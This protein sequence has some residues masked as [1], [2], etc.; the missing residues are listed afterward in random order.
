MGKITEYNIHST[1]CKCN[2]CKMKGICKLEDF[3]TENLDH[4]N[5][6]DE[7]FVDCRRYVPAGPTY[8]ADI[9]YRSQKD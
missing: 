5:M 3:V 8:H 6:P 1:P 4:I 2:K 9:A 7:L